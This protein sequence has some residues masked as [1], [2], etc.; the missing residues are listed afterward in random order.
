MR[1]H[2][3]LPLPADNMLTKEEIQRYNRHLLLPQIGLAGQERLKNARVLVIGAGGLGCPV[4]QY[5]CAVGV[6]QIGIVDY[7]IVE[8]TNLQ[9]Q[10]L[11][12]VSDVGKPKAKTLKKKLQKQNPY[13]TIEVFNVKLAVENA[14][15]IFSK[16]DIVLDGTDNFAT[17]YLVNDACF[18]LKKILVSGS[19]FKFE[20]QVS[21]FDFTK[22][23]SPTYRCLFPSPPAAEH[24]LSCEEIGVIGILP[25]IVGT[26]M[27][28]ETIKIIVGIGE[29]LSGKVLML[30]ALN[31]NFQTVEFE[32]NPEAVKSI[33]KTESAFKRMDYEFFCG[34]KTE[35][36]S[37]REIS[38]SELLGLISS[39]AGIQ[40]VDVREI[41]EEP[42]IIEWNSLKIPLGEIEKRVAEI[43]REE[44]VIV[45]CQ[46]G[47][48]SHRAV[49][50]LQSNFNFKNLFNL[51]GG[52]MEW[53]RTTEKAQKV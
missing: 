31:T 28:N 3:C 51:K 7:D 13:V 4:L 36:I 47:M 50:Q 26:L 22:N 37:I 40:V 11:F 32:R 38:T 41:W 35:D 8:E 45:V 29:T 21:V 14:L 25:G 42:E 2:S 18:L 12:N 43:S 19:I 33:P 39:K 48:R 15:E 6:G 27:A 17:R 1:S 53:I 34:N 16:Y 9:R 30:N 20:G 23:S 52:V 44:K 24:A 10:I 46:V 5:L 49:A